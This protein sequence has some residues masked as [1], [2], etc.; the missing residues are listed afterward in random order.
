MTTTASSL[1]SSKHNSVVW[2]L[3]FDASVKVREK[4]PT[5]PLRLIRELREGVCD[6]KGSL[7]RAPGVQKRLTS[8][9]QASVSSHL[10]A[11]SLGGWPGPPGTGCQSQSGL[12]QT[13]R[14]RRLILPSP[15]L[16]EPLELG[17][18][19]PCSTTWAA[20][21]WHVGIRRESGR[22][23]LLGTLSSHVVSSA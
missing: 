20:C 18:V 2:P 13:Q 14:P 15:V 4:E 9:S 5:G 8:S 1:Y 7:M 11:R 10:L 22:H 3:D 19:L 6:A 21:P 12:P 16:G 17:A 23:R